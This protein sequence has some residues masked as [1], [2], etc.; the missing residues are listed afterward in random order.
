MTNQEIKESLATQLASPLTDKTFKVEE[1]TTTIKEYKHSDLPAYFKWDA[2]YT[3]W[4]HRVRIV[5]GKLIADVLKET[6]DGIEYMYSTISSAFCKGN[7]PITE[8]EW[9]NVMH[10]FIKQL[11]S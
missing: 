8:D 3:P 4:Y 5:E 11:R 7:K 6:T 9:R 1:T 2:G 10:K